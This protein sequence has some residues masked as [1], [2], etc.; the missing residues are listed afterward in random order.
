MK[1][2]KKQLS[3]KATSPDLKGKP[4][5]NKKQTKKGPEAPAYKKRWLAPATVGSPFF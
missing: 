4:S 1:K 3:N 5:G 2:Q